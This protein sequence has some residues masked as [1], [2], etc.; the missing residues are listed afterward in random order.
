MSSEARLVDTAFTTYQGPRAGRL[1][2]IWSLA[3]WSALRALGAR[4]GWKAKV[5]PISLTLLAFA[6]ALVVLGLRA[7]LGSGS[8]S[9]SV[10][11]AVPYSDYISTIA[12]VVLVFSVVITPELV[13]PDRRDRTLSLY[14]STAIGRLDYVLGKIAAALMPLLLVTLA[15]VLLLYA[16]TVLF[17]VHP[18]GYLQANWLDLPRIIVSSLI[19]ATFYALVGLAISSLTSR[20][21]FA[22]G[23]YLAFLAISTVMGGVLSNA[24]DARYF[25]L[26]AVAAAPIRAGQ[27]LFPKYS[28]PG[29]ISPA[30]WGSTVVEVCV[31]AVIV[32]AVRY[33]RDEE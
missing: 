10:A 15:P 9:R 20:R 22:V 7:I 12:I 29:D 26:L 11:N 28:D 27:G 19:V 30:V 13:C 31:V 16:G 23:G 8:V 21:A 18:V 17:S 5:I 2:A 4:R 25:R 33:G 14:F 24:L 1:A 32:L 6:P 3:R